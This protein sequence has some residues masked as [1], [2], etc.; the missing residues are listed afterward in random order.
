MDKKGLQL[1]NPTLTQETLHLS[2]GK[3]DIGVSCLRRTTETTRIR[4]ETFMG[5]CERR[6]DS[7]VKTVDHSQILIEIQK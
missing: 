3:Q 5:D 6:G 4:I 1:K 2:G 7:S